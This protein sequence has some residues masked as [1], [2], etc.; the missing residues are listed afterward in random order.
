MAAAVQP[1][2]AAAESASD[3]KRRPRALPH[4]EVQRRDPAQTRDH[5]AERQLGHRGFVRACAISEFD[6]MLQASM[7]VNGVQADSEKSDVA[8]MRERRE[9]SVADDVAARDR[10]V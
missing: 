1:D 5:V 2:L 9:D 8:D 4:R 7:Q 6:A 3:A 10:A